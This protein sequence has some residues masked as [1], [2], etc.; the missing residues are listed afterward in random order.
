MD[1]LVPDPYIEV[2]EPMCQNAPTSSF[3]DVKRT[4]EAD[5]GLKLE[6]TFSDFSEKP[7][8]SA[9]IAQVHKATLKTTGEVVA[10]KVQHRVIRE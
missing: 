5:T 6:E 3:E 10:V 1:S 8:A 4:F 9:S 7:M 2:F